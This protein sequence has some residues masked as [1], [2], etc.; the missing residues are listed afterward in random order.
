MQRMIR[1]VL[2]LSL[3]S[4][5]LS[6]APHTTVLAASQVI[7]TDAL[8]TGWDNYS[9][10][11]VNLQATAPVHTGSKSIAV[12]YSGWDGLYLHH[13]GISTAGFSALSFFIHGGSAGSQKLNVFAIRAS[14]AARRLR[15]QRR[16]PTPGRKCRFR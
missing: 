9:W 3:F 5:M 12:T 6:L 4:I 8:A 1:A 2:L 11:A 14:D 13:P 10:A 15:C 7:Y 16:L